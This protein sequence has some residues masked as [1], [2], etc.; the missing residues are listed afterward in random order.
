M[1]KLFKLASSHYLIVHG[2]APCEVL[3]TS[4][5]MYGETPARQAK[6]LRALADEIEAAD[7]RITER[8]K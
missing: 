4:I 6:H 1:N 2:D 8:K 7:R 3:P 5:D